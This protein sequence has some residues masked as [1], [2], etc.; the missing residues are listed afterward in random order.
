[1]HVQQ[2]ISAIRHKG[3]EDAYNRLLR[4]KKER[5]TKLQDANHEE[6][7]ASEGP[8][9]ARLVQAAKTAAIAYE[10]AKAG[11]GSVMEYVFQPYSMLIAEKARQPWTKIMQEQ[12]EAIPWTDLQGVEH[13]EQCTKSWDYFLECVR[14]HL[15]II[16]HNDAAKT[17][18]Y[19]ISNCLKKP[20]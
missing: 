13:A 11:M 12:V 5:E 14:H 8:Q 3:L 7:L 19:Y 4:T 15:L 10:E 18:R 17:K 6:D 20:N 1:M 16:F 2:A 9:K